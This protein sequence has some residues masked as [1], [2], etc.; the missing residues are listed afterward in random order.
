ME[1]NLPNI[2]GTVSRNYTKNQQVLGSHGNE[3]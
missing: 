1:K 2:T 3:C